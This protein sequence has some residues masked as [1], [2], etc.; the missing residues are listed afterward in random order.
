MNQL[1]RYRQSGF[2]AIVAIMVLVI[3]AT[4]SA[5]LVKLGTTQQVTS[6]QDVLSERAWQAARAGNEW[7]MYR[8]LRLTPKVCS[9]IAE[10]LDLTATAGFKT[11][12]TCTRHDFN[13]GEITPGVAR[14]ITI[15]TIE[16]VACNSALVCP[17]ATLADKTHYIERKRVVMV[18]DT[19]PQAACY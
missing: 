8:A 17:D 1:K 5:G 12:V 16:A 10:T 15:Y 7:G 2:G 6:A 11:T 19:N 14:T 3:L 9:G 13:E 18:C 4:I